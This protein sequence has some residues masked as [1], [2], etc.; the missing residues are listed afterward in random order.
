[1]TTDVSIECILQPDI[2]TCSADTPLATAARRMV[3]ARCSSILVLDDKGAV[4]GIWTEHDALTLDMADARTFQAPIER[5]MSSPVKTL[6]A[7]TSLGEAAQRF[8]EERVR[9]FLVVDGTGARKGIV[10]QTDIVVNQGIEYF[11]SLR[12]LSSVLNRRHAVIASTVPVREAVARMH[13]DG[14]DAVLVAYEDGSHGILTERDVMRLISATVATATVG[15]VASRPLICVGSDVSLYHARH[16]FTDKHIRHLGVTDAQGRLLGLVAFADILSSIEHEYA[17]R[18]RET[19]KE[20]EHSLAISLQHQRLA[21]KVF[22][23]TLEGI[24]VTNARRMIESVNPAF[25]RITGYAAAEVIGKTPSLLSSGRH[26]AAFFRRMHDDLQTHG[27]WQG[28]I[29]NRRRNGEVYPEWLTINT[30]RNEQGEI[31]NYVGVFS[32]ITRR[33]AEQEQMQFL[34]YHDGL[35][36]LPN[37]G[38]FLDRLH[39]AA[40]HAHRARTLVAVLFIDLDNFKPVNDTLGHHVGDRLLQTVAERLTAAVREADTVARLGGDEF[41][42]ILESLSDAND[43][44]LIVQKIVEAV[45]QPMQID[46]QTV[47]ATASI[48][49]SLY[50]VDSADADDLLRQAD[51]AMYRAKNSGG[52]G[53]CFVDP[54]LGVPA[55]SQQGTPA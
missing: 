22:E 54:R 40:A 15:D 11:L 19:L 10:T 2:L 12:E 46:G 31:V 44:P 42:V 29:W 27:H 43:V 48:G 16:L 35:T 18:L 53:F 41:T 33:K 39:H 8:R 49:V 38:L 17:H 7:S 6:L 36:G 1:V 24:L 47:I 4:L 45:A 9:H 14:S 5:H 20:R 26:D 37:R 30:V 21:A 34:A 13:A 23:S 52:N 25:T 28:E 32:D 50:P 3:E 55:P 51:T